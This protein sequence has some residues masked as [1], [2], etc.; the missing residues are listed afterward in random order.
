VVK[1]VS[2]T[3]LVLGREQGLRVSVVEAGSMRWFLLG[4]LVLVHRQ[5]PRVW[6][7]HPRKAEQQQV[8]QTSTES[9]HL[10]Q[11]VG[12]DDAKVRGKEQ[13]VAWL[14][15]SRE[16][17]YCSVRFTLGVL[18]NLNLMCWPAKE[19]SWIASVY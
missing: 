14:N 13:L 2:L 8:S 7:Q 15:M 11:C 6:Q 3:V 12:T 9:P 5:Y 19:V 18:E 10:Q 1:I 4:V 17:H 16:I